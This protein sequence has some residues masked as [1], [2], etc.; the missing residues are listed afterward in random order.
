MLADSE[1]KEED[2]DGRV[3]FR[4]PTK[5]PNESSSETEI[6]SKIEKKESSM[7]K[8]KNK[9]L[10]SFDDEEDDDSS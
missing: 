2:A 8:V 7:K 5:R 1:K 6:R 9:T 4:K 10:L 3:V